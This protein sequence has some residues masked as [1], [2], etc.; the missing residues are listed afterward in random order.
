MHHSLTRTV[1]AA[2]LLSLLTVPTLATA[3]APAAVTFSGDANMP[4]LRD[5]K[6]HDK[7]TIT[8][9]DAQVITAFGIECT[10]GRS[11]LGGLVKANEEC[12]VSGNG[13][14]INPRDPSQQFPRTQ[15]SGGYMVQP[16][17]ATDMSKVAVNYLPVGKVPASTANLKGVIQLKPE[18]PSPTAGMLKAAILKHLQA[19]V[20]DSTALVDNRVDTVELSGLFIPSAGF[21]SDKGCTW[22][23]SMAF[24]Y[25]TDSWF[26]DLTATCDGQDYVLKGN[27]PWV[28][29]PGAQDRTQYNLTLT[30]PSPE[31]TGDAAMFASPTGDSD[32]FAAA[33]GISGTIM[34]EESQYVDTMVDGQMEHLPSRSKISGSITGQAVPLDT[35]RSFANL[36]AILARTFFGA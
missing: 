11:A 33:N 25:Q 3:E 27:M 5:P 28:D 1:L 34:M 36:I 32:M 16:D 23:G 10:A 22:R 21:A 31:A 20:V 29:S 26:M 35:V 2:A 18:N 8:V 15:Y 24:A 7:F 17:G 14:I 12:A 6:Q 13:S 4:S 30:L 19:Q 9:S